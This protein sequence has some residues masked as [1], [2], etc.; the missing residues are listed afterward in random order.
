MKQNYFILSL[1]IL[2]FANAFAQEN[3]SSTKKLIKQI[4]NYLSKKSK[5]TDS[6]LRA[7]QKNN[8]MV[9]GYST[10]SLARAK[11][12]VTYFL[13]AFKGKKAKAYKYIRRV[14]VN[15][16]KKYEFESFAVPD[17]VSDSI[18]NLVETEKTWEIKCNE[19]SEE[20]LC[21]HLN[22]QPV[23]SMIND[24]ASKGLIIITK[25]S[26]N[27]SSFYAPEYFE[28]ECCPGNDKRKRFLATIKPIV[29]LFAVNSQ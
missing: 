15:N 24:A 14:V 28:Y 26:L 9:I 8:D 25:R 3:N 22:K 4:D 10:Y 12:P 5:P 6:V 2:L 20:M 13:V 21:S 23:C 19:D 7:L 1:M 11:L 16:E 29:N 27:T 17:I 18:L